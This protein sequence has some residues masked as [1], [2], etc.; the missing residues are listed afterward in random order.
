MISE[1]KNSPQS[2]LVQNL[3]AHAVIAVESVTGFGARLAFAETAFL[4]Q[5]VRAQL[6]NQIEAVLAL[7]PI[8]AHSSSGFRNFL[9]CAAELQSRAVN[10]RAEH[11][12]GDVLC[13]HAHE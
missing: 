12:A 1:Q 7:C 11:V 9:A 3:R 8:K 5:R 6:M 4:H 13:R 10:R 2:Q